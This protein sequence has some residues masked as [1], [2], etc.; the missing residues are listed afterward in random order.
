MGMVQKNVP[1]PLSSLTVRYDGHP[2]A[3]KHCTDGAILVSDYY[4]SVV[5]RAVKIG[6]LA[7]LNK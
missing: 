7:I 4:V 6:S 2:V 5:W 1:G 3:V